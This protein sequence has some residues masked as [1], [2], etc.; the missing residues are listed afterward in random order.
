MPGHTIMANMQ[1]AV[2]RDRSPARV[3]QLAQI[4]LKNFEQSRNSLRRALGG[5]T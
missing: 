3:A 5:T 4:L 2:Q 1:H